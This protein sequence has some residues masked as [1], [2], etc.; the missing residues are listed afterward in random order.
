[1]AYAV[2]EETTKVIHAIMNFVLVFIYQLRYSL[3]YIKINDFSSDIS[4]TGYHLAR[5]NMPI[6]IDGKGQRG[7]SEIACFH[8]GSP[9]RIS[10]SVVQTL[11]YH[12]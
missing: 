12:Y 8:T 9:N 5:I 3:D 10:A 2:D 1:M 6:Q 7:Q 4:N 11:K